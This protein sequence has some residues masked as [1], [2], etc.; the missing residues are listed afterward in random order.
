MTRVL[1]IPLAICLWCGASI[2]EGAILAR[3]KAGEK[4][5]ICAIGTS[6]TGDYYDP[7]KKTGV[8]SAWFPKLGKW[9]DELYPGQATLFNEGIGGAASK[10]TYTYTKDNGASGHDFQLDRAFAHDPDVLFVE[11]ACNDAYLG[12]GIS[13]QMSKDN[14]QEMVGRARAWAASHDKKLEIVV[15]TMNNNTHAGQRPDLEDYYQGYRD[16]VRAN[17]LLLIDHYPN[18]LKLYNS[19]PDHATWKTYVPDGIHP[20]AIGAEHVILPEIQGA[21]KDQFREPATGSNSQ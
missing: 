9:L 20:I 4:L 12:Y 21:L 2:A 8:P 11:F 18:W 5:T 10:Y 3:L 13:R 7:E 1:L 19:E 17:G 6:V 14:L 15:Q 16:V